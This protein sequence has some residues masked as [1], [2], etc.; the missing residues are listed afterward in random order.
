MMALEIFGPAPTPACPLSRALVAFLQV[1]GVGL[2]AARLR[3]VDRRR[4]GVGL[5]VEEGQLAFQVVV[6]GF[7]LGW[8]RL[9]QRVRT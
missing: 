3:L 9:H 2:L 5:V 4:Q 7:A 1:V 6:R 8:R